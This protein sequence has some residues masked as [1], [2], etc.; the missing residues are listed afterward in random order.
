M[1]RTGVMSAIMGAFVLF[2][3]PSVVILAQDSPEPTPEGGVPIEVR[4]EAIRGTI[5]A[6]ASNADAAAWQAADDSFNSI[7]DAIDLHRDSILIMRPGAAPQVFEEIDLLLVELDGALSAE[8]PV[9][10][11]AVHGLIDSKL[12]RLTP[13][14]PSNASASSGAGAVLDWRATLGRIEALALASRWRDMRNESIDLIDDIERRSDLVRS[15]LGETAELDL[16]RARVFALRLRAAALDQSGAEARRANEYFDQAITALLRGLGLVAAEAPPPPNRFL[17]RFRG[18]EV[19]SSIGQ[20]VVVPIKAEGVPQIGLGAFAIRVLWSPTALRYVEVR[21]EASTR[22]LRSEHGPGQVDISLPQAPQGPTDDAVVASLVFEVV[23][24]EVRARDYL[25]QVVVDGVENAVAEAHTRV[26]LGD[27]PKAA[28]EISS[29]YDNFVGGRDVQGSVHT[30]FEA[31][32]SSEAIERRLLIALELLSRPEPASSDEVVVALALV[33]SEF[34][35]AVDRHLER[36]TI[37]KAIPIIIETIEAFDA[38]GV[39]MPMRA[40]VSGQVVLVPEGEIPEGIPTLGAPGSVDDGPVLGLVTPPPLSDLE[41]DFDRS[42]ESETV[43]VEDA[44][45]GPRALLIA[46]ALAA[47]IAGLAVTLI[48]LKDQSPSRSQG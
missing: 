40:A 36:H 43:A 1:G 35:Q 32:G 28:S 46:M 7:L 13:I 5:S 4:V 25:P 22:G 37:D 12:A 47:V 31:D 9:R 45:S 42:P 24:D 3:L 17:A 33:Q 26:K 2:G 21:P 16:E 14:A 39:P 29:A 8:D 44:P 23:G 27:L 15:A 20:T 34:G 10:V 19:E 6:L 48:A 18:F 41:S 30:E 11:R 38:S